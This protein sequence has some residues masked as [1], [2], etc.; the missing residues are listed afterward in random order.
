MKAHI[1]FSIVG[2]VAG[3]TRY[4]SKESGVGKVQPP[5]RR[6]PH[7]AMNT[8]FMNDCL[9]VFNAIVSDVQEMHPGGHH[10]DP[11]GGVWTPTKI[12]DGKSVW[13]NRTKE[14]AGTN[15]TW[16]Q[17]ITFEMLAPTNTTEKRCVVHGVSMSKDMEHHPGHGVPIN[18]CNL[19]NVFNATKLDF[20]APT[21]TDCEDEAINRTV[22]NDLFEQPK[23]EISLD[24]I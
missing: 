3:Y 17:D 7:C 22:C 21:L 11:A 13:A 1:V 19:Y 5:P 10:P 6:A 9:D 23:P 8:L 2:M 14:E 24:F 12:V 18:F 4:L 15:H 20:G 16:I